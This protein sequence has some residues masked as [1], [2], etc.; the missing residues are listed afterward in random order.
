MLNQ[1][2]FQNFIWSVG[3]SLVLVL[4][5]LP[6]TAMA[7]R[8]PSSTSNGAVGF[9][10]NP[11]V[12]M[13][14]EPGPR[15]YTPVSSPLSAA[16]EK[17]LSTLPLRI[18]VGQMLMLGFM[19]D[20][21]DGAIR[22]VLEK[23][24]PGAI[25]VFSR[26]IKTAKQISEFTHAAQN[27]SIKT[28]KL[29]LL[30]AC[31]QEGGDVIRLKTSYPLPSALAFGMADD[32]KLSER[33]GEA[34]GQLMKTLGFNMNLAPV[35]D[36]G[37]S[38]AARFI[39]TRSFSSDPRIVAK[40]GQSF[41]SGLEAQ[42]VLPTTK[43]FPGHGGVNED[44]HLSTPLK[45]DTAAQ[46]E[47]HDILPF[48][49]MRSDF[50]N[51]WAVMLAHVAYPGLDPSRMP[52]TFSKPIVTDLLR[53]KLA[54]DGLV[55]T[56]DIEMAGASVV[57]DVRERAIR[58]VEAGVDLIML[59]WNKRMQAQVSDALVAS[60]KSG[61][62]PESRIDESL[63][64]IIAAKRRFATPTG[65]ATMKSLKVAVQNPAF[66]EI[67]ETTT[68]SRLHVMP[69]GQEK[70][71]LAQSSDKPILL[72]SANQ[73]F[74]RDF[75]SAVRGREIRNFV[76]SARKTFD[77]DR[78]MRANP[79]AIG[80]F[81]VSGAQLAKIA[82]TIS[83]DVAQRMMLVTVEAPGSMANVDQFKFLADVYYR[84]P[85]LG[86]MIGRAY[87]ADPPAQ[88]VD[89]RTPATAKKIRH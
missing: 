84:H 3:L 86:A 77:V 55:V 56:D 36:V 24:H 4:V 63:R 22:P 66:K 48:A 64:R 37:D 7:K 65:V 82:A 38:R 81:Y 30:I 46:L 54:F 31:D 50:T 40:L 76:L 85:E 52:A 10:E 49:T 9:S 16:D 53:T 67:A 45:E 47:L 42:G 79:T 5:Y 44:S 2:P 51:S 75:K 26:N 21:V 27:I 1:K 73:K 12:G 39:G 13:R 62:I 11:E 74:M 57:T 35:L 78:V 20:S 61:R 23:L 88:K 83:E 89:A 8:S 15:R 80:I 19:G 69:K 34:T 6:P 14:A 18:K 58:A 17:L 43:H 70:T 25:V 72:F 71:F 28:T 33:A 29:P 87:F 32:V 41:A 60:V 59:A 68:L